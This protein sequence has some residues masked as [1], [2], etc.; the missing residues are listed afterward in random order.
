MWYSTVFNGRVARYFSSTGIPCNPSSLYF[1]VAPKWGTEICVLIRYG[2]YRSF[3]NW[4]H[5]GTGFRCPSLVMTDLSVCVRIWEEKYSDFTLRER[6]WEREKGRD[7][8]KEKTRERETEG[9]K[10]PSF[11]RTRPEH[12]VRL[13]F[14]RDSSGIVVIIPE[15][16]PTPPDS[17][18]CALH[19]MRF[20]PRPQCLQWNIFVICLCRKRER[21]RERERRIGRMKERTD[22]SSTAGRDGGRQ[23]DT[24]CAREEAPPNFLW[25]K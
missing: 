2:R 16:S 18:R 14:R 25:T 12:R 22:G 7:R 17:W 23:T 1:H 11:F 13:Y 3:G 10:N 8:E 19:F 6:K 9:K 20:C 4:C 24:S 21:E 5:S 15:R